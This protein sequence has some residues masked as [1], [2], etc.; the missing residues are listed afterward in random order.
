MDLQQHLYY[1]RPLHRRKRSIRVDIKFCTLLEDL[2]NAVTCIEIK[3]KCGFLPKKNILKFQKIQK[4]FEIK[5]QISR[6]VLHQHLKRKQNKIINISSYDPLDLFSN[7]LNRIKKAISSLIENPQNN[8]R[9]FI[10]GKNTNPKEILNEYIINKLAI[11]LHKNKVLN[12][13]L[14]AQKLDRFNIENVAKIYFHHLPQIDIISTLRN[15]FNIN[16]APREFENFLLVLIKRLDLILD[17]SRFHYISRS[18]RKYHRTLETDIYKQIN[19]FKLCPLWCLFIVRDF[20]IATTF[21]DCSLMISFK[22]N[23]DFHVT[24]IDLD[25]KFSQ[26]IPKWLKEDKEIV[27]TYEQLVLNIK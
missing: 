4:T 20:L 3:P 14:K 1:K 8:L 15:I 6:Y 26:K 9:I 24:V 5:S 2:T 11:F 22:N 27:N 7:N 10:N 23:F 16:E 25:R 12:Y 17:S 13:I 18:Y 19:N 21:K